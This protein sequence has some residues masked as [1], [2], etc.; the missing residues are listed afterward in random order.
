MKINILS[1]GRFKRNQPYKDIFEYY[2]KRIKIKINLLELKTYNTEKKK[3]LE[4]NEILK[5]INDGDFVITLDRAGDDLS[6]K[7]FSNI[8]KTNM[9][10][11]CKRIIFLIGSEE[12]LD[13]YFKKSFKTIS[14]GNKTWPHL[15]IR[16]MLIEQIYRAFEIMKNSQYHK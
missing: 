4:K 11:G 8:I 16:I 14:F 7:D 15:I 12:G 3:T 10:Q 13:N 1:L 9:D 6:S 5:Y 2:K